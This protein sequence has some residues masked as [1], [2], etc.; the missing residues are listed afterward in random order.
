MTIE[1]TLQ[2]LR[3]NLRA[4]LAAKFA[5]FKLASDP[6]FVPRAG[7]KIITPRTARAEIIGWYESM[8]DEGLVQGRE[9]F[10]EALVVEVDATDLPRLNA[11]VPAE[12]IR[13]L[14]VTAAVLAPR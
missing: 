10:A 11:Y 13:E 5:G 4:R 9:A 2:F 3:E 1:R 12:L 8:L 6:A 7:Q 14:V